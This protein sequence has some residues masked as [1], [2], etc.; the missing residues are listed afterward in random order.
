MAS[1]T[2][3]EHLVPRRNRAVFGFSTT[4]GCIFSN[5]RCGRCQYLKDQSYWRAFGSV[6]K[7]LAARVAR[8]STSRNALESQV[9]KMED[10]CELTFGEA[11]CARFFGNRMLYTRQRRAVGNNNW[12]RERRRSSDKGCIHRRY[13][14]CFSRSQLRVSTSNGYC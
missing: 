6:G 2:T 1:T 11:S 3:C 14:L 4:F 12:K 13:G 5:A 8:L 10:P 7:Y 9:Q